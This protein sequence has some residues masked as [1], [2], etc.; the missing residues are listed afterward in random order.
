MKVGLFVSCYNRP[1]Y[2]RR[3]IESLRQA[4]L[5]N[6]SEILFYN[7]GSDDSRVSGLLMGLNYNVYYSAKNEGIKKV[8]LFASEMLF[9]AGC[10]IVINLD[11]DAIVRPDF[12]DKLLSVHSLTPDTITTGFNCLTK[13]KN[14]TDRHV[15]VK[16]HELYNEKKSVGGINMLY[17]KSVFESYIKPALQYSIANGGNWDHLSCIN[18]NSDG[19]T[20][21]CV[22]PSVVQH[23]GFVSSMGHQSGGEP[24]DVAD[25][26][27]GAK[28]KEEGAPTEIDTPTNQSK[29][30]KLK[31]QDVTLVGIDCVDLSRLVTAANLTMSKV[32]FGDIKLLSSLASSDSR[33]RK[34]KH[35]GSR[36][37]YSWFMMKKLAEYIS[38]KYILV[39]QW[40][41]Y[42]LNEKAWTDEFY[43]YDYIGA[44]WEWYKDHKKVGNGGFSFRTKKIMQICQNDSNII[45]ISEPGVSFHDEEDHC[46]CRIYREYLEKE[47]RLKYA[48][49]ELARKFSIEGYRVPGAK[50]DGEFGFHGPHLSNIKP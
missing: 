39:I 33:V 42:V 23:I 10:D 4:D 35:I 27:I 36:E 20:V 24:P 7:D 2:L 50:W 49:V 44:P 5:S 15:V 43:A 6:V 21:S 48:P 29:N 31:L 37:Q 3:C 14:G 22:T 11:S 45:P 19:K 12:I 8:V 34:I 28:E 32:E 13:N 9:N 40:D 17:S 26:F 1:E 47:Y 30:G 41:G 46:I 38:T 25:D 18:L 16:Q